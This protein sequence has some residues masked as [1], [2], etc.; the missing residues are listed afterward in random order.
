VDKA[1]ALL[2]KTMDQRNRTVPYTVYGI[3]FS[4]YHDDPRWK[5][6][7]RKVGFAPDQLAR[8][9]FDVNLPELSSSPDS[10]P[11]AGESSSTMP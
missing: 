10:A 8:I 11:P 4:N 3:S 5:A 2:D 7:L 1:F 9:K 6:Y